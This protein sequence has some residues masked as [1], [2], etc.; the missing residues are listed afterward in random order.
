MSSEK[1]LEP[2][3]QAT[4]PANQTALRPGAPP[5]PAKPTPG[6]AAPGPAPGG[7][8]GAGGSPTP[9]A[10]GRRKLL[11]RLLVAGFAIGIAVWLVWHVLYGQW[12]EAT[13]NAYVQGNVVEITPQVQGTVVSIGADDGDLVRSGD[14]LVKLDPSDTEV[15]LAGAQA[16]LAGSVRKVR[17]LYSNERGLHDSLEGSQAEV[18]ARRTSLDKARADYERRRDLGRS[19]AISAE[20]LAHAHD[21]LVSAQSAFVGAQSALANL[22]QQYQTSKALVDDTAVA[23][24]PDVETAAARLRAAYLENARAT[25]VTPVTGYVAKRTVQLSQRVQPGTPLMAVVPLRQVWVDA[26]FTE[27]Q[28]AEMRIGQPVELRSDLY[29]GSV[30]YSGKVQALGVGTGS[31]FALLP[32]QNATGNWIKIVQRLPV[33]IEFT[34]PQQLEKHPLRI[35]LSMH[36]SVDLHNRDGAML[37]H[38]P[39]AEPLFSSDLY[40]RQLQLANA[41]VDKVIHDNLP[42]ARATASVK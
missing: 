3:G 1:I 10:S 14:T 24:H 18:D 8:G 13:D 30:R 40:R 2:V 7:S 23:S 39:P 27:K 35:G 17:G 34:D 25:L 41:L 38:Q 5:E 15:E 21:T 19:G 16:A 4:A 36:A 9:P 22:Q 28:V 37:A 32:A 31:A 33:R 12:Y 29:G 42:V 26:N 11:L 20:E 6:G